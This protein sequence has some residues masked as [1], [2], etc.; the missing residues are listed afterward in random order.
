MQ[1]DSGTDN[2]T[3]KA[4]RNSVPHRLTQAEAVLE[5]QCHCLTPRQKALAPLNS[6]PGAA[7]KNCN[8]KTCSKNHH[9]MTQQLYF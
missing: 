8:E 5:G 4:P 9:H 1:W 6:T 2:S 7:K 3:G